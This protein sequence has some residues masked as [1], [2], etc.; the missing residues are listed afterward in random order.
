M[1]MRDDTETGGKLG[2]AR[3]VVPEGLEAYV[4]DWHMS[5]ALAAGGFLFL[6]GMAASENGTVDPDPAVQIEKSF[7]KVDRTLRAAGVDF[8]AVVEMTSYHVR[9]NEHLAAFRAIR[10]QYV[11][12]PY[13]AWTAI[14]VAGF[15]TEGAIVELRVIARMGA[16]SA[17][18]GGRVA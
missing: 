12:P 13:P 10:D 14:E 16:D 6:T 18:S 4:E 3:P 15:V 17:S 11:V 8:S 5:P 1:A 7:E 2:G 9:L